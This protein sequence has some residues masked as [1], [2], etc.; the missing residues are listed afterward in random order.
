MIEQIITGLQLMLTPYNV[1]FACFGIAVGIIIGAIPGL[2]VTMALA[3]VI[4]FTFTMDPIPSI[5]M[6]LG[7]YK[8]GVY[9]GSISAILINT[10]GTP[11]AS[12]TVLDGYPMARKGQ[13]M[14]GLKIA[15][16]SSVIADTS[17]DVVLILVAPLLAAVALEFGP[18][19][20]FTLV[21]FSLTIIA[22]VSGKSVLKG[23][24][25][26]SMGLLSA[27]IGIDPIDGIARFS[28][29][30]VDM[31]NGIAF[32]PMLIGLFAISEVLEQVSST[33]RA[34]LDQMVAKYSDRPED[35][36]LTWSEL[37]YCMRTIFRG[38]VIGT[39]LGAIPGIGAA[40]ASFL[41]YGMAKR[42]SKNPETF[43]NGNIE[44]VAAAESGNNAVCGATLI[45]LLCLGIPG[46]IMTAVLMGAFMIQ[47]I[48]PGPLMFKDHA[49]VVYALFVGLMVCN[50]ANFVFGK[51]AIHSSRHV[52]RI[53]GKILYP[54]IILL[55]F[56]GSYAVNNS[57]FDVQVM[58]FFGVMGYF[59]RKYK[60]PLAPLLI[61]FILGPNDR[62][63][64]SPIPH[65][66]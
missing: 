60:F 24:I 35:N 63:W 62:E 48:T 56:I 53:P 47:G 52:I 29:G 51:I 17:S 6:L 7:I 2:T 3:L 61:A 31:L 1:M 27:T 20:I 34:Y 12:A 45:P 42:A 11:A 46:D 43:G 41:N 4:P 57:L 26:A 50:I 14:K 44:G 5:A 64:I 18:P 8:G 28:F 30:Y 37:K 25:A 21:L 66:I 16:Y 9:G 40:P 13:G 23:L 10:P 38:F 65:N 39:I 15:L 22:Y 55:C 32:V 58:F 54:I 49:N 36:Q 19:E 33:V 59:M